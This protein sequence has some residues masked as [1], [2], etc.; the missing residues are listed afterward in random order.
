M[1]FYDIER[2]VDELGRVV[3]PIE[4]RAKFDIDTKSI[5][6]LY[7]DGERISPSCPFNRFTA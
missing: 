6:R 1:I 2:K 4:L 3:L 7:D 5:V